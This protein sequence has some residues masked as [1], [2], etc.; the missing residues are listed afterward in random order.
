MTGTAA[1][2]T[3][4]AEAHDVA[5]VELR[6]VQL[7]LRRAH[8]AGHGELAVRDLVLVRVG[9]TD[10]TVGWGECSALT[11]PT[12]NAEYSAGAFALLRDEVVPW[13]L[14]AGA[15]PVVGH[16]MAASAIVG[17]H[18]DALLRRSGTALTER[19]GTLHGR[20]AAAVPST[21]VVGRHA[22]TDRL[23][24]VVADRVGE[25]AALVKL[26]ITPHPG[27]MANL[28][29]V[30]ATWPDLP[31]AVD[32]NGTLDHRSL[33]FLDGLHLAYVEQPAPADDLLGSAAM[34]E[35]LGCPVALDESA[36][37][38]AALEVALT[39]G[40]GTVVNVKPA[41]LGG[42]YAAAAVARQAFD[43]GCAV[44]VGGM[45]ESGVGRAAALALAALPIFTLPSDLGPSDRYFAAD[46]TEAIV[47]DADGRVVVPHGPG[48]GVRPDPARLDEVTVERVHR[49]R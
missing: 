32:A 10:G 16:P 43:A 29:A 36:T 38:M 4:V 40:A 5:E 6:R 9:L 25:G 48:I 11:H 17:A 24:A 47:V 41:R 33:P 37:S 26:K 46:V 49:A 19:L 22:S 8:R 31:L 30:R 20:P 3:A 23:L 18:I 13:I 15:G 27:D 7:P 2:L 35:R 44:F 42:P 12:Y 28:G 14:G 21:A 1:G 39:V 45:L 34:A